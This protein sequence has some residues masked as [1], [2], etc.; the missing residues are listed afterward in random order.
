MQPGSVQHSLFPRITLERISQTSK[1]RPSLYKCG[2][3]LSRKGLVQA[4]VTGKSVTARPGTVTASPYSVTEGHSRLPCSQ[5]TA[6]HPL[7]TRRWG[8]G[9]VHPAWKSSGPA[10]SH[11]STA[12]RCEGRSR[13]HAAA[14]SQRVGTCLS[15]SLYQRGLQP[16]GVSQHKFKPCLR[17]SR[18]LDER[19]VIPQVPS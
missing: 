19:P 11:S 9:D 4:Q 1:T 14:S 17:W 8:D 3:K 7:C 13:G 16:H 15:L 2:S 18:F 12:G 10:G 6:E 5:R